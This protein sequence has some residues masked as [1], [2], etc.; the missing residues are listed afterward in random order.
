MIE[1]KEKTIFE[2]I[3]LREVPAQ[4]I[5]EDDKNIAFLDAFA[6]DKG[7]TLVIPKFPYKNIFE[8]PENDFLNLQKFLKKVATHIFQK[9]KKDI[10]IFQRNG[11]DAGQE[12]PHVH[13]HILPRYQTEKENPIFNDTH[14]VNSPYKNDDEKKEFFKLLK[15]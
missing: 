4:I 5:A 2:K 8:M 10:A 6:F 12:V 14:K 7:H 11:K 1:K 13:F 9:T 3:V 15:M